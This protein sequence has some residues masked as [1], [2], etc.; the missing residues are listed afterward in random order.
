MNTLIKNVEE[1]NWHFLKVQAA[2]EKKTMGVLF[3]KIIEEY[4]RTKQDNVKERWKYI[5][6]RKPLLTR[7]EANKMHQGV[8]KFRKEYGFEG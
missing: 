3:N 1:S 2:K 7:S 4:K 5:F 8:T 6:T